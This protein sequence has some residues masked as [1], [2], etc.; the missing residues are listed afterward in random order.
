MRIVDLPRPP[1][2]LRR[3]LFRRRHAYEV[4]M[5]VV[6][7]YGTY[8]VIDVYEDRAAAEL[9]ASEYNRVLA[10]DGENFEHFTGVDEFS[11]YIERAARIE[12]ISF[13]P[14]G[15]LPRHDIS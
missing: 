13:Y 6:G 12:E 15:V 1:V 11:C 4:Y 7:G 8:E 14:A 3:Q 2:R 5:V 10:S 9:R